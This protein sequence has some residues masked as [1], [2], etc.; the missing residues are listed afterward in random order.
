V[1]CWHRYDEGY[2]G[3]SRSAGSTTTNYGVDTNWYM[4]S[5][6]TDHITSELEKLTV[7]DKYHGQDQVHT[8]SGSGM[9]ISNVGRTVLHTPHKMLHLQNVLH[10]PAANKNL[11][12]VHRLT[13]DNNVIV[14]FHPNLFLI[15]DR[16]TKR[17]IHQGRREG[18]L[19]PLRLQSEE[20]KSRKQVLA[21]IKSSTSRWHSRLGHPSF[22]IVERVLKNNGLPCVSDENSSLVCDSCLKAKSHQLPYPKS[23]S[24][25]RAPLDL[26]F[27]DVWGPAPISVGRHRYY[28]SFIDDY[29]KY[30]WI[31]LIRKKSDVFQVFHDFQNLVERKFNK[32]IISVQSDWVGEYE[33]LNSFF[34]RIGISHHVS[35][36]HAHQQNGSAERKHRHIV[37]VG[38]ALLANA[39][40]PLKFWD[41][42]FLT[43]TYLINLLPSKVINFDTPVQR[44]L[45]ETPDYSSLRVFGCACWPNLRPYNSHK[46]SFRST[47]CVFLGYSSRHKGFKCLE[48]STGRVYISRDVT[49]DESVFPFEK[50]HQNAGA[51]LRKEILLLPDYLLN[52]DCG[53]VDCIDS[54]VTNN[55]ADNVP[56]FFLE[57]IYLRMSHRR[58]QK[59]L[60]CCSRVIRRRDRARDPRRIRLLLRPPAPRAPEPLRLRRVGRQHRHRRRLTP[61][62][63]QRLASRRRL[64][65]QL[66]LLCPRD[67]LRHR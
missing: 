25:S 52:P 12:S 65:S 50:L 61:R 67:R 7:R 6:A 15:K 31:Y 60:A 38:L 51:R 49:F 48:P 57:K 33:K 45:K 39:S 22:P 11:A 58:T 5:G 26:I 36:P 21:T 17:I 35:C 29:S 1:D 9:K 43:A 2:Q 54:N 56:Q 63:R 24:V 62:R 42:A 4:D 37:E 41:E 64:L 40:M 14:E 23:T 8:A 59:I 47:R 28:V 27:F 55:H 32:K 66:D 18:G 13:S 44:L 3:N 34:Q 53:V 16:V 19:Y 20:A 10:V 46:L 30:T